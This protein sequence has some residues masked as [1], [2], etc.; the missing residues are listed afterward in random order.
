MDLQ[1]NQ[2]LYLKAGRAWEAAKAQLEPYITKGEEV[3]ADV[4]QTYE[5]ATAEL[6]NML[7]L[8]RTMEKASEYDKFF[9]EVDSAKRLQV[10]DRAGNVKDVAVTDEVKRFNAYWRGKALREAGEP[11]PAEFQVKFSEYA[12]GA[13]AQGGYLTPTLYWDQ[14]ANLRYVGSFMRQAGARVIP[15]NSDSVKIPIVSGAS[16]AAAL[17]AEEAAPSATKAGMSEVAFVPFKIQKLSKVSLELLADSKF[18]VFE[19]I[20]MP[21][22]AQAFAAYENAAFTTGTG[23]AEPQGINNVTFGKTAAATGTFTAAELIDTLHTLNVQYRA[24]NNLKWMISDTV[25]AFIRKITDQTGG[26]GL[27]NWIWQPGLQAGVADR[28]LGYP[29]AVNNSMD[30]AFTTAKKLVI[31]GDFNYYWIGE[32]QGME[33][34]TLN[35]LYA[36]NYQVGYLATTRIDGH[37]I[38]SAAFTGLKLA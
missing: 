7:A 38:Q 27:G 20:V 16:A 26:T 10:A 36:A 11:V 29:V 34:R 28:L 23:T 5:N 24:S 37:I 17:V 25:I 9:N 19:T 6:D 33:L 32:R 4:M 30:T 1:K 31:F 35:E 2:E 18:P 3:P 22:F 12:E 13:D 8:A 21:D 14:V 15:I